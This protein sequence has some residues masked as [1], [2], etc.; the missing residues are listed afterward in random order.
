MHLSCS[1]N[2]HFPAENCTFL[3]KNVVFG[4]HMAG[5]RRKLQEGFR[6]QGQVVVFIADDL[7]FLGPG[8]PDLMTELCPPQDN[9]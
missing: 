7:G 4:V 3:Q 9:A 2:M 1:K 5:N 8:S 6:A